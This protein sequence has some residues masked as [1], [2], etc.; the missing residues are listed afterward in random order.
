MYTLYKIILFFLLFISFEKS[1]GQLKFDTSIIINNNDTIKF[2]EL[3]NGLQR[4]LIFVNKDTSFINDNLIN[5][6]LCG[7]KSGESL[8]S[9]YFKKKNLILIQSTDDSKYILKFIKIN[10]DYRLLTQKRVFYNK[11][12]HV[13]IRYRK[14]KIFLSTVNFYEIQI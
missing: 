7:G 13:K 9:I 1:F 12:G 2:F 5:C 14:K 10:K 6:A 4:R 8:N 3:K 11:R